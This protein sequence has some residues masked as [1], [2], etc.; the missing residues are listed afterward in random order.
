VIGYQKRKTLRA[1]VLVVDDEP[2]V[3]KLLT[4]VLADHGYKVRPASCAR[5]ALRSIAAKIPDL[6][7]LDILMPGLDGIETCRLLKADERTKAIPV[8][9]MTG[10]TDSGAKV[11]GF[12]AGGVDY[13]TKPFQV[14]ELLARIKTHLALHSMQKQLEAQNTLLQQQILER[15]RAEKQLRKSEKELKVLSSQLLIAQERERQRVAQELHDRIGQFL[16]VVKFR[17][18]HILS[19]MHRGKP[20]KIDDLLVAIIP[21][22]QDAIEDI[23]KIYTDLR[24]FTIDDLG[25]L[26]TIDWFCR[27]FQIAN[28]GISIEKW[29]QIE[30]HE[31]PETLRITIFRIMEEALR[32]VVKY[33]EAKSVFLHLGARRSEMQFVIEDNGLGFDLQ[34]VFTG[35]DSLRGMGLAS[36]R[37]RTESLGGRFIIEST[38]GGGTRIRA[39]WPL[40]RAN[41]LH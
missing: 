22:I 12:D 38:R 39:S 16:V 1:E 29:I 8:V 18:A 20:E 2:A 13:V 4:D 30:E 40:V 15:K 24:P 28:P 34:K 41:G 10:Q 23:R 14:E 7:L 25:I 9:F 32:N 11:K 36:M 21:M 17:L 35:K 37:Q 26:A 19:L 27:E 5:L 6:I 3:L 31:V 33:S